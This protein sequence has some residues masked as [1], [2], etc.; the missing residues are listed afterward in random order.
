MSD[1]DTI[2]KPKHYNHAEGGLEVIE[3]IEAFRLPF[4]LGAVVKYVL[5]HEHKG[6]A[7]DLRKALWFLKRYIDR[8]EG[9]AGKPEDTLRGLVEH[10]QPEKG[11]A[12]P[13][14]PVFS[15][16]SLEK[17]FMHPLR[18]AEG[19]SVEWTECGPG[20]VAEAV[21]DAPRDEAGL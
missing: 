12:T 2:H 13:F 16:E 6:G 20:T 10:E 9:Q 14:V 15:K 17:M 19:R 7:E 3:V 18:P 8:L 21:T 1:F 4:H 5:R 11:K